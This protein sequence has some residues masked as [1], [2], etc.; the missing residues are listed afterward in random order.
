MRVPNFVECVIKFCCNLVDL[1]IQVCCHKVHCILNFDLLCLCVYN[2]LIDFF[3]SCNVKSVCCGR[4]VCYL[5]TRLIL[6][7]D[8]VG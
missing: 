1:C 5:L 8:F 6:E 3:S 2:W 7:V 4:L